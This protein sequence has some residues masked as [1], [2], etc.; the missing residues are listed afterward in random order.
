MQVRFPQL[1]SPPDPVAT[2][3]LDPR[4]PIAGGVLIV[5]LL[6]GALAPRSAWYDY[7]FGIEA[8]RELPLATLGAASV[9]LLAL[10]FIPVLGDR[11]AAGLAVIVGIIPVPLRL[12]ALLLGLTAAWC[13][14]TNY[15]LSGDSMAIVLHVAEGKVHPSHPLTSHLQLLVAGLPGLDAREGVRLV[16]VASG[17]VFTLACVG[18]SRSLFPDR[19]RRAGLTALLL[20][21]G[22]APL[23][24]GIIEVYGTLVA[25][26]AVYLYAGV[27]TIRHGG[28]VWLAGLALG[29]TFCLHGSAGLLLP[30]LAFLV[31]HAGFRSAGVQR[32]FAAGAGFLL[33]VAMV[34]G[35]LFFLTW[36]GQ[37]PESRADRLGNF[38]GARDQGPLLPL[39]KTTGNLDYRYAQLDL[40]HAIGVA[41]LVILAAP[42][43]LLLLLLY[44][45]PRRDPLLRWVAIIAVFLIL[46]PLLWNVSFSL[47]RDWDLFSN[48]GV[49]LT[50]LGGIVYL[51][52]EDRRGR[53]VTAVAVS[54]FA[55]LPIMIT[56]ARSSPAIY[57]GEVVQALQ[58]VPEPGERTLAAI[59]KWEKLALEYA[60]PEWDVHREAAAL[61]AR[62]D[63]HGARLVLTAGLARNPHDLSLSAHLGTV[64]LI[65]GDTKRGDPLLREAVREDPGNLLAWIHLALMARGEG[66][67]EEAVRLLERGIRVSSLNSQAEGACRLLGE[68][69]QSLGHHDRASAAFA[70]AEKVKKR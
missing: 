26:T 32:W 29:V 36:G 31:V 42:L 23:F 5:L 44:R 65:L 35:A 34:F 68:I 7:L 61:E 39:E 60:P 56:N 4:L 8:W 69:L 12:P 54:L 30:S 11:V 62:R 52:R 49:P 63:Y 25:G 19:A 6:F 55:L 15:Q 10:L 27:R 57:A 41:N 3:R 33:P 20:T 1:E 51:T 24:F 46:F 50:L 17:I 37:P 53:I 48:M 13:F 21:C 38:L 67:G 45:I 66:D 64:Y 47:R 59:R 40:D 16:S 43:G 28:P 2:L 22:V 58:Q 14:L 70:V 18:I 9:A